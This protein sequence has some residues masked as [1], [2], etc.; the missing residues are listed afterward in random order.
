M[1]LRANSSCESI[2]KQI[3]T[4]YSDIHSESIHFASLR[5]HNSIEISTMSEIMLT[6][7]QLEREE[8]EN[9]LKYFDLFLVNNCY[10]S[11]VSVVAVVVMHTACCTQMNSQID[12][13]T[14]KF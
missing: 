12:E 8:N 2:E 7:P 5:R 3:I 1:F 10:V 6:N 14:I 11:A 4:Q 13:I 9:F